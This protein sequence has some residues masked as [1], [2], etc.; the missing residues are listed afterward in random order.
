[1]ITAMTI[2]VTRKLQV[3]P[4]RRMRKLSLLLWHMEAM[5]QPQ[6]AEQIDEMFLDLG[7]KRWWLRK[8]WITRG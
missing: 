2:R 5:H 3:E 6:K 7:F 1:M 8:L 4:T